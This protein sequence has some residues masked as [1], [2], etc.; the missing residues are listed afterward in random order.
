M[1]NR[2]VDIDARDGRIEIGQRQHHRKSCERGKR[3]RDGAERRRT[4]KQGTRSRILRHGDRSLQ[5]NGAFVCGSIHD[6]SVPTEKHDFDHLLVDGGRDRDRNGRPPRVEPTANVGEES[7]TTPL[8]QGVI[9]NDL[10]VDRETCSWG[11]E[12]NVFAVDDERRRRRYQSGLIVGNRGDGI[13]GRES[14][15]I[16]FGR[17]DV[18]PDPIGMQNLFVGTV[19]PV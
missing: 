9:D 18:A 1:C 12:H 11:I 16:D 19:S 5:Q 4:I 8:T 6:G 14:G 7:A 15:E 13:L 2:D 17:G 3:R 10:F